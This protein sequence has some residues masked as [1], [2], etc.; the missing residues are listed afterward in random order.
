MNAVPIRSPVL[1]GDSSAR[2]AATAKAAKTTA[3]FKASL[4]E[5]LAFT[6][7]VSRPRAIAG[8]A[9][10]QPSAAALPLLEPHQCGGGDHGLGLIEPQHGC[11]SR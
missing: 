7:T 8:T 11:A 1:V 2:A 3:H 5:R 4:R 6:G 9:S 10:L